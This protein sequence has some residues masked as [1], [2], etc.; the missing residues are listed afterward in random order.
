MDQTLRETRNILLD[1][2]LAD[3]ELTAGDIAEAV[4]LYYDAQKLRIIHANKERSE[5]VSPL[6]EW[7][8]Y[9]LN[10]GEKVLISKLKKWVE[11]LESPVESKWAYE[12]IGIG[13]VIAAGLAAHIDV[14]KARTIS[15]LWKFGGQ[16]PGFDKKVKGQKLPYNGRL[17]TLLWK[18]GESFVKVSGKENAIYGQLY[19]QFKS[20]EVSRNENGQYG[21]VAARE[22]ANKKFKTDTVTRKRLEQGKLSDGHL[23]A[24][25]KRR[26]IKIFL[27]HYWI[28][29]REARGLAVSEPYVFTVGGHSREHMI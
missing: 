22:L 26:V 8:D 13:P 11:S 12:Q 27:S 16:A 23:H 19:V 25:A 17:K 21:Q 9:W 28:K 1:K 4:E 15:A 10:A 3:Y 6:K 2:I 24:R 18:L 5:G 29:G 14:E 20:D 7:F